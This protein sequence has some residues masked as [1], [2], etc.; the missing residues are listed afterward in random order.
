MEMAT[1]KQQMETQDQRME[2][3]K[4]EREKERQE[5]IAAK[6]A[7]AKKGGITG[8]ALDLYTKALN[9]KS[10]FTLIPAGK[11]PQTDKETGE[12]S[13]NHMV[14]VEMIDGKPIE[15]DGMVVVSTK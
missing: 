14:E 8:K 11:A 13:G 9:E 2:R 4:S 3:L 6:V 5:D 7:K 15:F 12:E 1:D 10:G